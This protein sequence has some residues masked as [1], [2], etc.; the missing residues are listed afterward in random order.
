MLEQGRVEE[1]TAEVG[2]Y[3]KQA[4]VD[5]GF[6]HLAWLLGALGGRFRG[7]TVHAC[8]AT[9]GAGAAVVELKL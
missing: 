3:A 6:K 8:G 7:A 9:W 1:L 2:N 5:M 4:K